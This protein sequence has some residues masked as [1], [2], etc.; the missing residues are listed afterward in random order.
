[1]LFWSSCERWGRSIC[2]LWSDSNYNKNEPKLHR[3]TWFLIDSDN[4][5]SVIKVD[6]KLLLNIDSSWWSKSLIEWFMICL[7][8]H[9]IPLRSWSHQCFCTY[10]RMLGRHLH[11]IKK[12][13]ISSPWVISS[14]R[15]CDGGISVIHLLGICILLCILSI[16]P[17][18][19]LIPL[20]FCDFCQGVKIIA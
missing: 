9:L 10:W 4:H 13:I 12:C 3:E 18:V 19:Q 20:S 2:R 14:L 11:S 6:G 8:M 1:M 5:L 15:C 7:M 17:L 16:T